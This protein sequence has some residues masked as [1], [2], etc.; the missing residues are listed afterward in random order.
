MIFM[1]WLYIV[2]KR[3]AL[4][5]SLKFIYYIQP[6]HKYH[7]TLVAKTNLHFNHLSYDYCSLLF[8]L[9]CIHLYSALYHKL[10]RTV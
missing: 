4:V 8:A 10:Y 3:S 9:L 2:N 5:V 7:V 6:Q 1:L